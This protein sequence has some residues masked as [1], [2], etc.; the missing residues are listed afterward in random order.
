[1]RFCG[2]CGHEL[3]RVPAPPS[4][5]LSAE[6]KLERIQ[7]YLPEGLAKKILA[8]KDRIEGERRLVTIMFCDMK[9][10]TPLTER[11]GPKSELPPDYGTKA[12][13]DAPLVIVMVAQAI[14]TIFSER[15]HEFYGMLAYH[16]SMA[17]SPEETEKYLIKAGEEALR[18]SASDEA[19]HYYEKRWCCT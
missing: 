12:S 16:Y 8:Q 14:K 15:L 19:L 11:L 7:R 2:K 1:M 4:D 6:E 13:D 18:T 3:S 9:E 10:F 5:I 17:E